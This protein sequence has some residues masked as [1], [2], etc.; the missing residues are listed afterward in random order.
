MQRA[1]IS[2]RSE[3]SDPEPDMKEMAGPTFVSR[4]EAQDGPLER[5][6]LLWDERRLL[7][8]VAAAGLVAGILIAFLI[9]RQYQSSVQLMP[10]DNESSSGVLMAA[11]AARA[12][13]GLG[14]VA[15]DLLGLKS[16][17]DLFVGILQSRTIED[18]LVQRFDLKKAY[19]ES[20]DED[21]RKQLS[22]NTSIAADRKSGIITIV[23]TDRNPIRAQAVAQGYV[24]ELNRL[25]TELSTSAAYRERVFLEQRLNAVKQDLDQASRDFGQFASKNAAI[26]IKEQ[27][28]AMVEAAATLEGEL[29][30]AQS[31]M[32]GLETIYTANNARVRSVQ[33]RVNELQKQLNDMGG[34]PSGTGANSNGAND[35]Y[36]S[37][38]QLPIL[39]VTYADL[40]RRTKI[41]ET[42]YE[43]LTQEYELAKVQEAKETPSVK[44][45]DTANVPERKSF[46]PRFLIIVLCTCFASAA[47]AFWIITRTMWIRID[48]S[49]PRKMLAQD[50]FHAFNASMP[51]SP[52]NGSRWQAATHRAWTKMLR[53]QATSDHDPE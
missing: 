46:P 12:G 18:R 53:R 25:V 3:A 5:L 42:V 32:K 22:E 36:P 50:V 7:V 30:A 51:W 39:G 26:D 27:G 16:S 20:I 45:L 10:P 40:Y 17:G 15:G 34:K 11:M 48:G 52:P 49:D 13:G 1:P 24:E 28:R 38:R 6:R 41:Q 23:V 35:L 9:P 29:I 21:A 2:T 44:V 47:G 19:G 31:E 8:R 4:K 33:A 37:I 14:G 43:T